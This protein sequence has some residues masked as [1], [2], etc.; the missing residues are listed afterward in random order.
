MVLL[1]VFL[2]VLQPGSFRY[3]S[4][5]KA[6]FRA[7]S[8]RPPFFISEVPPGWLWVSPKALKGSLLCLAYQSLYFCCRLF[9]AP[10][11]EDLFLLDEV[12][13]PAQRMPQKFQESP[14]TRKFFPFSAFQ[15]SAKQKSVR[16]STLEF[17][18]AALFTA[19]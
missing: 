19:V 2:S 4:R 6:P 15:P 18:P 17:P 16:W 12:F 14:R 3:A 5:D 11:T 7:L 13:T 10:R 9:L 1:T 8:L